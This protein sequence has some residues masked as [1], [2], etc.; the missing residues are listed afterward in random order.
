MFS[1]ESIIVSTRLSLVPRLWYPPELQKRAVRT[2]LER[3]A[4][5]SVFETLLITFLAGSPTG[6]A[7]KISNWMHGSGSSF[8]TFKSPR[9]TRETS[10][11]SSEVRFSRSRV[12]SPF[13]T[14]ISRSGFEVR[15]GST[16]STEFRFPDSFL[17]ANKINRVSPLLFPFDFYFIL[18]LI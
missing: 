13:T 5:E 12:T 2:L 8:R 15:V 11:C 10:R 16:G 6:M 17:Y 7:R 3:F 18:H 14:I 9:G 4:V 1:Q